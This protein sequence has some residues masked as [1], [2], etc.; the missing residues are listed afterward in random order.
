M[1]IQPVRP[2]TIEAVHHSGPSRWRSKSHALIER[3]GVTLGLREVLDDHR[4]A[5]GR[6][7]SCRLLAA[8]DVHGARPGRDGRRAR[9]SC[10]RRTSRGA[11]PRYS[12]LAILTALTLRPLRGVRPRAAPDRTVDRL[13]PLSRSDDAERRAWILHH[14]AV[15]LV[16]AYP[17]ETPGWT[18][19]ASTTTRCATASATTLVT[20]ARILPRCCRRLRPKKI[21]VRPVRLRLSTGFAAARRRFFHGSQGPLP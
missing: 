20:A 16:I 18:S 6:S 13:V 1:S 15:L 21:H 10:G 2:R 17:Y 19:S 9:V 3:N 12:P 8:C 7:H 14:R 11:Q 5:A 4:A